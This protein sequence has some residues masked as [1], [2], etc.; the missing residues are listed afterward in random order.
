MVM[1][2]RLHVLKT[3]TGLG[4]QENIFVE[5]SIMVITCQASQSRE[6]VGWRWRS[7]C[8]LQSPECL[9]DFGFGFSIFLCP[10]WNRIA[11]LILVSGGN[12]YK[13]SR[14]WLTQRQITI[15]FMFKIQYILDH[16]A[17]AVF[18]FFTLT[19]NS[20]TSLNWKINA[21]IHLVWS[22]SYFMYAERKV[23]CSI[24]FFF[25]QRRIQLSL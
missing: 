21:T 17:L 20:I 16:K 24:F 15:I 5:R 19:K 9:M 4:N 11:S 6:L 10:L 12:N 13:S 8:C 2:C 18:F 25:P 7:A 3:V 23:L 22:P 1:A 14:V